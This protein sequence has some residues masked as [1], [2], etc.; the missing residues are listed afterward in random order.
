MHHPWEVI[1]YTYSRHMYLYQSRIFHCHNKSYEPNSIQEILQR[2]KGVVIMYCKL[3][4]YA[5]TTELYVEIEYQS[6]L[7]EL[8]GLQQ[9]YKLYFIIVNCHIRFKAFSRYFDQLKILPYHYEHT[10]HF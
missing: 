6:Y 1:S 8:N 2:G 4:C 3:I 7:K 10:L 9:M 5:Y